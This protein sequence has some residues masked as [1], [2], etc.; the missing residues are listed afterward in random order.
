MENLS[1]QSV[2]QTRIVLWEMDAQDYFSFLDHG[3]WPLP[4][5]GYS[6]LSDWLQGVHPDDRERVAQARREARA[7]RCRFQLDYRLALADGSIRWVRDT[8]AP[9]PSG[10]NGALSFTGAFI[11]I[12]EQ[13][14]VEARLVRGE[15]E[16]R[17]LTE[18][19]RDLIA[20]SDA[21]HTY[22]YVSPSHQEILG[23]TQ[24]EM[25]GTN[26]LGYLHPADLAAMTSAR[27]TD[28]AGEIRSSM[29]NMR[30]RHKN[31][32]W[33]WLGI[34]SRA[35]RDP[36]SGNS[37]GYVAVGRDITLQLA[38]E[39]E[40]ARREERFRS[41][42]SLSSDWYWETDRE[43]CFTFLSDGI[44]ARLGLRPADLLGVPLEAFAHD[45]TEP[46]YLA[47]QNS[48]LKRLPFRDAV[49]SV[50]LAAYPG[51]VRYIRISGEPFFEDGAFIGY[52]GATRDVTH[53]VRNAKKLQHLA[54]HDHLTG[55]ANRAVLETR[56]TQRTQDR[57]GGT[58]CAIFFI[59]LDRFKDIN[60][61]L[62]HKA[63]DMLLEEIAARLKHCVRPDD[64]VARLGG[65]EFVILA[66]CSH[67][68]ESA[69][70]IAEKLLLALNF[71]HT[72]A[73]ETGSHAVSPGASIGISLFPQDGDVPE[74]LLQDADCALYRAK[75]EGRGCYRFF[76][77][78]MRP[79][80]RVA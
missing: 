22:L 33:I 26:V 70:A 14:D 62:G 44:Q 67:G 11:D 1:P 74:R 66:D 35:I 56:L 42:T 5:A 24:D 55:L 18:N 77:P 41:L 69:G 8:G 30:V 61:R 78:G 63:G 53:E 51:V 76:D 57:R 58:A 32:H 48:V 38:A 34:N 36:H 13:Y 4:A 29:H 7:A 80:S 37:A 2:P 39:R 52:R 59:D 16:H 73:T 64:T 71:P 27:A 21:S 75:R 17:L 54:T 47:C 3:S 40:L 25:V 60:D 68:A 9:R 28:A 46:G 10:D 15:A 19:V 72:L 20:Y 23:Y 6:H 12:S 31:G 50:A 79:A 45:T 65:D 43:N 49:Y